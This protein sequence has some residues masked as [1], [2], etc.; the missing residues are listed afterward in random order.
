MVIYTRAPASMALGENHNFHFLCKYVRSFL[1]WSC[2]HHYLSHKLE[3]ASPPRQR[4]FNH[5]TTFYPIHSPS[6]CAL[7]IPLSLFTCSTM[8]GAV[9]QKSMHIFFFFLPLRRHTYMHDNRHPN[10]SLLRHVSLSLSWAHI[11]RP[12]L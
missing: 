8:C 11:N 6:H 12:H 9:I 10:S 3:L 1:K 5:E 7:I 4:A 2:M